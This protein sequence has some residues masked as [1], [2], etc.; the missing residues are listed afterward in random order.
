MKLLSEESTVLQLHQK[1]EKKLA[2]D[3]IVYINIE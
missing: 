1:Y 2:G 3:W